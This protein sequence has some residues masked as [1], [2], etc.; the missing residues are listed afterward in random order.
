MAQTPVNRRCRGSRDLFC[1]WRHEPISGAWLVGVMRIDGTRLLT[2]T[3]PSPDDAATIADELAA[4]IG[5]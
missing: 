3:T 1:F 4:W 5:D 2:I